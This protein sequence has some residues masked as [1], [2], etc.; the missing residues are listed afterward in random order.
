MPKNANHKKQ[1]Q[2][3]RPGLCFPVAASQWISGA[4]QWIS[5]AFRFRWISVTAKGL[6]LDLCSPKFLTLIEGSISSL[7]ACNCGLMHLI[8]SDAL[9]CVNYTNTCQQSPCHFF[10]FHNPFPS[11]SIVN[12]WLL[13]HW[14]SPATAE[15]GQDTQHPWTDAIQPGSSC[16]A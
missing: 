5:G 13:C 15:L 1:I 6:R 2:E 10:P 16:S 9:I 8:S 11:W 4:F 12:A 3:E 14:S 7:W